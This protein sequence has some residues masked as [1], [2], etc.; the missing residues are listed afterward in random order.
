[1]ATRKKK[2]V[3]RKKPTKT[4]RGGK[5]AVSRQRDRE[6]LA[7]IENLATSV[8]K[9][10]LAQHDPFVDIPLRTV[11]NMRYNKKKRIL[12]M[13]SSTQRRNLFNLGQSKKFM[14]M[15]LHA[16]GCKNLLEADK[17]LSLRGM[18]YMGLHTIAGT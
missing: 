16:K 18:F 1:M 17:T 10:S 4:A 15:V 14:Q 6:T 9:K 5:S 8:V 3:V 12:E 7:K 13:G 11:T 2:V